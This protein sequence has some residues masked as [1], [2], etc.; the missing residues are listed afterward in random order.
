ME[1]IYCVLLRTWPQQ[2]Q[3]LADALA[4]SEKDPIWSKPLVRA[5]QARWKL[6]V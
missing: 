1:H 6:L 2:T 4:A 3:A 5:G